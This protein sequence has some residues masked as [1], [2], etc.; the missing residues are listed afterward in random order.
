MMDEDQGL[1]T[2][3]T[4]AE[5]IKEHPETLRVWERNG[6]IRPDR[7]GYQRKYSGNDVQRLKFIKYLMDNKGLNIAGVKHLTSMYS[8]W[9]KHNCSGGGRKNSPVPVNEF[10][11]CWKIEGTYC[12]VASDK[13]EMCKSCEMFK[14]CSILKREDL[15]LKRREEA[16]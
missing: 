9:Y 15:G 8:C 12:F 4:V 13:A 6:L 14:N 3:G 1:Y 10:K 11:A 7:K 5:L 16:L 2:I